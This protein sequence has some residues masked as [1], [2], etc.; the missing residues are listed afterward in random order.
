MC[1]TPPLTTTRRGASCGR[2]MARCV[3][4]IIFIYDTVYDIYVYRYIYHRIPYIPYISYINMIDSHVGFQARVALEARANACALLC[5]APAFRQAVTNCLG[6][7]CWLLFDARRRTPSAGSAQGSWGL[8]AA[9]S[10]SEFAPAHSA[11]WERVESG[12]E[13][14]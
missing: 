4:Y 9:L 1:R 14:K 7:H 6:F 11:V 8:G 2:S 13:Y 10:T 5:I 12:N 3:V